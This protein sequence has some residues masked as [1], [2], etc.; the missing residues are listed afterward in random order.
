MAENQQDKH[1]ERPLEC[2]DCKKSISI[3]YTEII[4]DQIVRTSMCADCPE[5]QK[6]LH[7]GSHM[8]PILMGEGAN[9][10][11]GNCGTT[12]ESLKMGHPTGCPTCYEIFE[13]VIFQELLLQNRLPS[14]IT[15]FKKTIPIHIGRKPGE[16]KELNL[17]A[18]LLALNEALSETLKAENYEEAALLRDQIRE[19]TEKNP[20]LKE[21]Q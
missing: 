21:R 16:A 11:C 6:R 10:A 5:Y 18:K 19:L 3:V 17:S 7:G 2:S 14:R 13:D 15:S 1:P 12:L 20:E 8:M 4:G 9:L